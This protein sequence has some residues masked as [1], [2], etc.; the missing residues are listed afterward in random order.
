[1]KII[2][3]AVAFIMLSIGLPSHMKES[4]LFVLFCTYEMHPTGMLHITFLVSS[5]SSQGGGVHPF[6]SMMFGCAVCKR[7]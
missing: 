5:K 4:G 2:C 7:S 1:V 3:F 6:G